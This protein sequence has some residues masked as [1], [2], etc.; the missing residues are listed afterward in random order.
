MGK[1]CKVCRYAFLFIWKLQVKKVLQITLLYTS[2]GF[3]YVTLLINELLYISKKNFQDITDGCFH[4]L[5]A[6][7]YI[8][9]TILFRTAFVPSSIRNYIK[10]KSEKCVY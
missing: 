2:H 6:F 7:S 5:H 8:F 10:Q 3:T 4:I 9:F 1:N